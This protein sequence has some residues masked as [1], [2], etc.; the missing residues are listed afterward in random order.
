MLLC[1][2]FLCQNKGRGDWTVGRGVEVG[3]GPLPSFSER[4]MKP[5]Y[6]V[7]AKGGSQVL[8][9]E[10]EGKQ[11]QEHQRERRGKIGEKAA[12]QN[13]L[14]SKSLKEEGMHRPGNTQKSRIPGGRK[15]KFGV[16]KLG[17]YNRTKGFAGSGDAIAPQS[18]RRRF[19]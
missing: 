9:K 4:I 5:Q 16:K 8:K 18:T 12:K 6:Q 14:S 3:R 1:P 2:L 15:K 7:E 11:G 17:K 19:N 10:V 13:F